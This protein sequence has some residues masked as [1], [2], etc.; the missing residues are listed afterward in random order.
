MT[1]DEAIQTAVE[2]MAKNKETLIAAFILQ[3]PTIPVDRILLVQEFQSYG[4]T[5]SVRVKRST[6]V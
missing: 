3:N 5:F 1:L 4:M 6:E 2:T